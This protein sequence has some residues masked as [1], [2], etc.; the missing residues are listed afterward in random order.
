MSE[1]IAGGR[2]TAL[3]AAFYNLE[4]TGQL[5]HVAGVYT[6]EGALDFDR[7]RADLAARM[8]LI[9]RY[10][11]RAVPVPLNLA[12]PTWEPDP[13][14]DIRHHVL[15][16]TL[17]AP[18]DHAQLVNLV[19]RLFAQPLHRERPL[20]ELHQVDGWHGE[21]SVIFCKVHHA[22]IDGV[23][24]VQLLGVL[25]DP[26]PIPQPIPPPAAE[27]PEPRPLPTPAL[28]LA[29]ALRAGLRT[30]IAGARALAA[31]VRDPAP[32][33]HE[34]GAASEALGELTRIAFSSVP[35]TPFNGHVSTLRRVAWSTFSLNEVKAVKNRLGGTVNDVVLATISS[36]LR[37]Y[38]ERRGLNPDRMELRAML[39]VNVRR[40]EEHLRLG[41]RVSMMVAP[42]PVGIFDPLERFRQVRAATGQ[43]KERGQAAHMTRLVELLE[44]LP[45]A[46]QKPIA[47]LQVQAPPVNTVCTNVPGPPV[48][49][50]VQGH[51]LET[52]VPV[53]PLAQGVGMAFAILS[54]ADTLTIGVT[55]DPALVPDSDIV[56]DLLV[57]GFEELRALAGVERTN[58]REPIRPELQRRRATPPSQVA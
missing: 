41:N 49:L 26:T 52:L 4:R 23:S 1:P 45:P 43:L 6:V 8:H 10:T 42:L 28:Q 36:G 17:R 7:L 38:L 5:L 15:R 20:W 19:S 25:F 24:G 33:L 48:S 22:M 51:R 32:L 53:V 40:P 13:H 18:G 12:H 16:H 37:G 50:F 58:R 44:M 9:P 34:L 57:A 29:R 27:P 35:P 14:F 39:P 54:Y 31:A 30:G 46:M 56:A 3:D 11:E 47:W 2:M 55:V 21:Q